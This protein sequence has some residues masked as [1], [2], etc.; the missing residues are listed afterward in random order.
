MDIAAHK[1]F[2]L[3]M[4]RCLYCNGVVTRYDSTCYTC[5]DKVPKAI[6]L[7][8]SSRPISTLSNMMFIASLGLTAFSF[9]SSHE[10]PLGVSIAVSGIFLLLKVIDRSKNQ[11]NSDTSR[12]RL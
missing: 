2:N 7:P 12:I 3:V 9:F 6:R 10:V 1:V 4:A 8:L 5:G 11:N